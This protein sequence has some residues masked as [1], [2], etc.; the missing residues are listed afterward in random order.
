[1]I[2]YFNQT[3]V[4]LHSLSHRMS[5]AVRSSFSGARTAS[6]SNERKRPFLP[7]LAATRREEVLSMTEK[8]KRTIMDMR[9][10]GKQRFTTLQ[11][12]PTKLHTT[13]GGMRRHPPA[14]GSLFRFERTKR[15]PGRLVPQGASTLLRPARFAGTRAKAPLSQT[16]FPGTAPCRPRAHPPSAFT[17][18]SGGS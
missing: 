18:T 8:E 14:F 5:T 10:A 9:A 1:M 11:R 6:Q 12:L 15:R 16:S 3:Y 17:V 13:G 2:G 4:N 7:P